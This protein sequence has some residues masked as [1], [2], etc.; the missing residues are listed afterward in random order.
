[1]MT[2]GVGI[3]DRWVFALVSLVLGACAGNQPPPDQPGPCPAGQ[4]IT[5]TNSLAVPLEVFP[6]DEFNAPNGRL[7]LLE[8][9]Q[10]VMLEVPRTGLIYRILVDGHVERLNAMQQQMIARDAKCLDGSAPAP[11]GGP[12]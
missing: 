9:H 11:L 10:S 2:R 6:R 4:R 3:G 12:G 1:M 7:A 5:I 8:P